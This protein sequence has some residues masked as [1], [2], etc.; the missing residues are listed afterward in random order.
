MIK[1]LN[2]GLLFK[3][4]LYCYRILCVFLTLF[5]KT[6]NFWKKNISWVDIGKIS[7]YNEGFVRGYY[8]ANFSSDNGH[9]GGPIIEHPVLPGYPKK[10]VFFYKINPSLT[11]LIRSR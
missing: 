7:H 9:E 4:L 3:R 6:M 11:K 5:G 1:K 2:I 10:E 8:I